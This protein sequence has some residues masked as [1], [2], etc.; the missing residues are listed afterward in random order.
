K[1]VQ[2]GQ[3]RFEP[4]WS[5]LNRSKRVCGPVLGGLACLLRFDA[6]LAGLVRSDSV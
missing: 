3:N 5:G 4:V 2:A 6:I 1:A